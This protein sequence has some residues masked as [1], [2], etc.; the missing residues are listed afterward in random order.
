MNFPGFLRLL[1]WPLTPVYSG[2]VRTRAWLYT[3]GW[4]KQ[5][6]LRGKVI[7]VGNLS[8]G[9]TG[10]TPM[11]IWLAEK[12]LAEGKRVAI[13]SRGYRGSAGTSDEIDLMRHRL[14]DRVAF[15]V[16]KDRYAQGSRI[17]DQQPIDI[18][19]LDDGFQ[20]LPLARDLDILL[21]DAT[22]PVH[23]GSLLPSGSLREPVSAMRRADLLI[24]TRVENQPGAVA[25]IAKLDGYPVFAA[26]TTLK[27]F[28]LRGDSKLLQVNEIGVGPFFAFCAIGN[29]EAFFRDLQGWGVPL[30][31]K[32]S[33]VDHHKF[34]VAD[35]I[36][37]ERAAK[38]A[39]ARAFVVT[40][41][42]AQN[43]SGV[44]FSAFSVYIVV[45]DLE[46]KPEQEF[47][48]AL[49]SVLETPS[50]APQ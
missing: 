3:K 7:S 48:A 50:G 30:A 4:F 43:L 12:F 26:V 42:D 20:H 6:R 34:T 10:K 44:N 2:F 19:L 32:K 37:L 31:G 35:A 18:F 5:R 16:G 39:G 46:I 23:R 36:S 15:G 40:E 17:E 11:V 33:F 22:R 45:I 29:P 8:V 28:H 47:S 14:Q 21:M 49:N 24:L 25:A 38:V 13:L 41:K 1:L 27:G 9:G